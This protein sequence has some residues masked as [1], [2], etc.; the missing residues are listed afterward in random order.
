M[1]RFFQLI[2]ILC[3]TSLHSENGWSPGVAIS[4]PGQDSLNAQICCDGNGNA[5]SIWQATEFVPTDLIKAAQFDFE[6][7][8][9]LSPVLVSSGTATDSPNICCDSFGNAF[10]VWAQ[11][12]LGN[13]VI[14]AAYF[15]G[16]IWL[17]FSPLS[18]PSQNS[19]V[20]RVCCDDSGRAVA[21]WSRSNGANLIIQAAH[22][23]GSAWSTPA[24]LSLP[25][26]NAFFTAPVCCD[27]SGNAVAVW[28]R[29]NGANTI[30]QA[31]YFNGVSWSPTPFD[32]SN[33]G[34]N[35]AAPT[36]CCDASGNAIAL[37]NVFTGVHE[38]IQY[39]KFSK[40]TLSWSPAVTISALTENSFNPQICCNH[41]S[42][43]TFAIWKNEAIDT[44]QVAQFNGNSWSS[45][46]NIGQNPDTN[47]FPQLCCSGCEVI[48]IWNTAAPAS[49]IQAA[50]FNGCSWSAPT[51]LSAAGQTGANPHVCCD[52]SGN[53]VA[54]WQN[55]AANVPIRSVY[56]SFFLA[57][58]RNF[59]GRFITNQSPTQTATSLNLSWTVSNFSPAILYRIYQNERL[60]ATLP[61]TQNFFI[62]S[63]MNTGCN[64]CFSIT[65]V[66]NGIESLPATVCF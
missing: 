50:R 14:F 65:K 27:G 20:P 59:R 28:S 47:T 6:T 54:I 46:V 33:T 9:W 41:H 7:L 55:P 61:S 56:S 24:N 18:D 57:P 11:N 17:S 45:P 16:S 37:W 29:F 62:S 60:I 25:G 8:S 15:N 2:S 35:A 13:Q 1:K 30:I 40:D 53:A 4:T 49:L 12:I 64:P 66:A 48:A 63:R 23:N 31:S 39:S 5:I 58:V 3:I 21:T 34:Q 36:V 26:Q 10:A 22:F 19:T 42:G 43:V 32:L 51:T 38:L 52:V 44:I